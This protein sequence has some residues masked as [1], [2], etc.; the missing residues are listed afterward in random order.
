VAVAFAAEEAAG[1]R[2]YGLTQIDVP[3]LG[4]INPMSHFSRWG[5]GYCAACG[6]I[7][8]NDFRDAASAYY[9]PPALVGP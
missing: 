8:W 4:R 7:S 1:R 6:S 2:C 3:G 9:R 5:A